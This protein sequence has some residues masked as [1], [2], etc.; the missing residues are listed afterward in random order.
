MMMENDAVMGGKVVLLGG[1][2]KQIL[3][4]FKGLSV[5]Q[6]VNKVIK[7]SAIWTSC[8]HMHLTENMR[9]R[10]DPEYAAW[11]E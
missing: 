5:E 10:D 6:V 1:D 8:T 9:A 7:A 11:V 3:P 4:I 2:M